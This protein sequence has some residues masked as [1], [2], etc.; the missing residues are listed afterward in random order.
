MKKLL[1]KL[2]RPLD[3]SDIDW[4]V[5]MLAKSSK[6]GKV[7]CSLLAYKDSRV[8]MA[9]LDEA[10]EGLWENKYQRDSKGVLQCGIGIYSEQLNQ[11]VWKWS[12]G[13]ESNNE[14][15]KGEYS[16]AFKRAG[17]MWGIGRELYDFP[18]VF[19]ELKEGEYYLQGDK[20]KAGKSLRFENWQF[21]DDN[22]YLEIKDN[23]GNSRFKT[24]LK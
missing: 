20:P 12:N 2:Q 22:G 8:D 1:T 7:Y 16:D 11:W 23:K 21:I 4:R 19:F 13:V 18:K 6:N 3:M 15:V 5:G 10:T 14:A 17:F 9:R 24:L